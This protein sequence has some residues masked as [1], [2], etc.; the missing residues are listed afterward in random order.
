M[1]SSGVSNTIPTVQFES[2]EIVRMNDARADVPA[3]RRLIPQ[4]PEEKEIHEKTSQSK[5]PVMNDVG[6]VD[7]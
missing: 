5:A 2:F 7:K 6:L 1:I 4:S 3:T